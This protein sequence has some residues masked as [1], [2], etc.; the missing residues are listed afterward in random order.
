MK[1]KKNIGIVIGRFQPFHNAHKELIQTALDQS[2][3][4]VVFVGSG[5][6]HRSHKNP[7]RFKEIS[8]MI[9]GEFKEEIEENKLRLI[10]LPDFISNDLI[11]ANQIENYINS[12]KMNLINNNDFNKPVEI[13]CTVF[14]HD[15][16]DSSFY[17][18]LFDDYNL[19]HI[20]NLYNNLS[21]TDIRNFLKESLHF[22]NFYQA[23]KDKLPKS[24]LWLINKNYIKYKKIIEDDIN[25]LNKQRE[26]FI[27]YPYPE[28]LNFIT[29]DVLV[30]L[31]KDPGG[32]INENDEVLL[33]KRKFHPG[34]GAYALPGGF[35]N[36]DETPFQ[37]AIR[38]FK[39]EV[40]VD[41]IKENYFITSNMMFLADHP[42]RS[43]YGR[44]LS[45]VYYL[46][47]KGLK[48]IKDFKSKIKAGDDAKE[49]KFLSLKKA[50][51]PGNKGQY[52]AF[53]DDHRELIV[54]GI[55]EMSR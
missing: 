15:K 53:F 13:H 27:D 45:F 37:G 43:L 47:I 41:L 9:V 3:I 18:K 33:I 28:T 32:M 14:G 19:V 7:F 38:E 6:K 5:D 21:S 25:Y 8:S 30:V 34:K 17:L 35:L 31:C 16:D 51:K 20:D 1:I 22:D 42:K 44:R 10:S 23:F 11:W 49:V 2:D 39:E 12:L 55:E 40:G 29:T 36:T 4:V 46:K 24:T 52:K 50:L 54:R 26:L 48:N